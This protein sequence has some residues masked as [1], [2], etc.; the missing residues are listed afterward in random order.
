MTPD[1]WFWNK[2]NSLQHTKTREYKKKDRTRTPKQ[3]FKW[4]QQN[5]MQFCLQRRYINVCFLKKIKKSA[6]WICCYFSKSLYLFF[7]FVKELGIR[8]KFISL[9]FP[10]KNDLLFIFVK[11]VLPFS[12]LFFSELSMSFT[13]SDQLRV[14][15]VLDMTKTCTK[16]KTKRL[17]KN[18]NLTDLRPGLLERGD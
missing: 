8:Y 12:L 3:D 5:Q 13:Q 1:I 16:I 7:Y 11:D 4:R 18:D 15:K 6:E 17:L 14:R 10:F 2:R 9:D